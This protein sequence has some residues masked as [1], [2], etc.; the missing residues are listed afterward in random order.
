MKNK[1]QL[2]PAK[3]ES[4]RATRF[5]ASQ[6]GAAAGTTEPSQSDQL[7]SLH[8]VGLIPSIP[9]MAPMAG[10]AYQE[11][12]AKRGAKGP[13]QLRLRD[14]R[15]FFPSY[16]SKAESVNPCVENGLRD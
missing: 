4:F 7:L 14:S 16:W 9:P 11:A 10:K 12:I 2:I 8:P 6:T 15:C 1:Q 3:F 5:E 13:L